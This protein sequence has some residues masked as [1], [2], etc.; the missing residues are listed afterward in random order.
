MKNRQ[1]MHAVDRSWAWE[2]RKI[3]FEPS[4][5]ELKVDR[6]IISKAR[7]FFRTNKLWIISGPGATHINWNWNQI[8]NSFWTFLLLLDKIWKVPRDGRNFSLSHS[9]IFII[10]Y[11]FGDFRLCVSQVTSTLTFVSLKF[12][13]NNDDKYFPRILRSFFLMGATWAESTRV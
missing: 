9:I 8:N 11:E 3:L 13:W 5:V 7:Q 10:Y 12:T 6:I 4:K 1:H 2:N